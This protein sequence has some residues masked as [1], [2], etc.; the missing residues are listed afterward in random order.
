VF[1]PIDTFHLLI[2][3]YLSIVFCANH[4]HI[5]SFELSWICFV[6]RQMDGCFDYFNRHNRTCIRR[7][8]V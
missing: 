2:Y 7:K 6:F 8:D 3:V 1:C 4:I 5:G